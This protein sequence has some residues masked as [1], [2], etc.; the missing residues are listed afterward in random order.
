MKFTVSVIINQPQTMVAQ[1]FSDPANLKEYQPGFDKKE[2]VSG[3][4]GENG[5][6]SKMYYKTGKREMELT[7][8]ITSNRLPDSFE[9]SYQHKSMD[10]TMKCSFRSLHE[11]KT[12]YDME[13]EYTVFRGFMPKMMSFLFPGIFKKQVKK[14]M[15]NFKEFAEK[16]HQSSV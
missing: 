6:I 10:N 5:A 9:A 1:L 15:D 14:W 3:I 8:T 2:L 7:E 12:R 16:Q 11:T 4:E 13:I